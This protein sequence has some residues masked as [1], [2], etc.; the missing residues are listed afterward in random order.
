[1]TRLKIRVKALQ[2][3][4]AQN[5]LSKWT[6]SFSL[7]LVLFAYLPT[8]QSDYVTQDQWRAF[9]Y[10][11]QAQTATDR[12]KACTNMLP[13]FYLLTGRPL[14]WMTECIE[15]AAV[16][17]I[18]DFRLLRPIVLFIVIITVL[19]LG[20][21]LAPLVGGNAMGMFAATA[22]V[23]APAYAFMY[24][25]SM[26]AAMVLISV[27]LAVGS[28]NR[29]QNALHQAEQGHFAK[30]KFRDLWAP[31][32]LFILGCLIY[33]AW[34]FLVV[35]LIW[36]AFGS[37]SKTPWRLKTKHLFMMLIFYLFAALFYYILVK[38]TV[39]ILLAHTG[40][41]PHLGQYEV[42]LQMDTSMLW[43]RLIEVAKYF[44]E[45]PP[46]NFAVPRGILPTLLG[47]FSANIA[48]SAYKNKEVKLP[49]AVALSFVLFVFGCIVLIASISPWLFSRMDSLSTRHLLPWY[50]F[51]CAASIGLLTVVGKSL[52]GR[53]SQWTPV[54]ALVAYIAPVAAVQNRLSFL[55]VTVSEIE[56]ENMRL[57]LDDWLDHRGYLNNRHLLVVRPIMERPAFV[58]RLLKGTGSTG[59][60][61]VFSSAKN[62]VSIPWMINALLRERTDHPV[63]TSIPIVDCEFD[64][65]CANNVPS[66]DAKVVLSIT[67][68]DIPFISAEDPFIINNSLLTSR[69][70]Y[71]SVLHKP[72][73]RIIASSQLGDYGPQGLLSAMQPGWH[74][75]RNPIYPQ[76]IFVDFSEPRSFDLIELLP[77]DGYFTRAPKEIRIRT[78]TDNK[79][80]STV[81]V[82][83][84]PCRENPG[85]PEGWRKVQLN[86]PV[87]ARFL[88]VGIFSNCGDPDLLTLRGLRIK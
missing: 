75:A 44:Y 9:R 71:P 79:L 37:D 42:K 41:V 64:Q 84:L 76:S 81:T 30:V 48:W 36:I 14:V 3:W 77:Q 18:S 21:I 38:I 24:F 80:W 26:P 52:P 62:P 8:L 78:S 11:T 73:L 34:A 31:F 17:R 47:L 63:G 67:N 54:F 16:A 45:M 69:P 10:S 29:L 88:E 59:E 68:G 56:I 87:N 5:S 20:T 72:S 50:L 58:E 7:F 57:R 85:A 4:R 55:E 39:A 86:N 28:F 19:Y 40:Y 25:Q 35:P 70:V 60:N 53:V 12:A 6:I 13:Q 65:V 83:S 1:M 32:F 66:N 46:L 23:M 51:F 61:T 49:T 22:F 2:K 15:H 43:N 82:L 33:P 74:A 27:V